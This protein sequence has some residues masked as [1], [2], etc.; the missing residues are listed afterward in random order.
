M[1]VVPLTL[2]QANALVE[3][4][5]RHHKPARGHRFSLGL[6]DNDG[7]LIGAAICGRPVARGCDPYMVLEVNRLVTGG[8]KNACSMLYSACARAAKAMGFTKIQTYI[9]DSEPGISLTA[10]GWTYEETTAGGQ[11]EHTSG[12]RRTDQPTEKKQRWA[13]ELN[14]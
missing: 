5:H 1:K 13:K 9:L 6:M 8:E 12:P 10:A 11:W 3:E 4:L 7:K 2:R 14:A